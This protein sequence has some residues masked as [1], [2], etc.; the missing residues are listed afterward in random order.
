MWRRSYQMKG[1]FVFYP[2]VALTYKG[3]KPIWVSR[4]KNIADLEKLITRPNIIYHRLRM[5]SDGYVVF[6]KY[7]HFV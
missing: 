6:I 2:T 1:E 5:L 3:R 7:W 4:G